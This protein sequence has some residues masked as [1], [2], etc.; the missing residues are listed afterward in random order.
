MTS[1]PDFIHSNWHK[2]LTDREVWCHGTC[3][4]RISIGS[5]RWVYMPGVA[6]QH[7]GPEW[8]GAHLCQKCYDSGKWEEHSATYH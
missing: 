2:A 6:R 4:L 7:L 5:P 3:G 1:T 8:M